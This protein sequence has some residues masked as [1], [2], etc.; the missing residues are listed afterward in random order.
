MEIPRDLNL[1]WFCI[2]RKGRA[3]RRAPFDSV[4]YD[5]N[6]NTFA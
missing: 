2:G 4:V 5:I 6:A 3:L 1:L